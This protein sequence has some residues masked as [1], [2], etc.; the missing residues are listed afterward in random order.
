MRPKMILKYGTIL[1]L[2][3]FPASER[4]LA[5]KR[6]AITVGGNVADQGSLKTLWKN[7]LAGIILATIC[8]FVIALPFPF[9]ARL[10][11][12]GILLFICGGMTLRWTAISILG[13]LFTVNLAILNSHHIVQTGPYKWVRHPSYTGLLL[14]FIG[15]GLSSNNIGSMFLLMAPILWAISNR[16][17]IEERLLGK[18]FN[19]YA[20]YCQKTWKLFPFIW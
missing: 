7:I 3:I 15:C 13:R 5:I 1:A 14:A 12:I 11:D 2:A 9:S 6:R 20:S 18:A 19:G 16:I 10:R 4:Y 8:R 17:E